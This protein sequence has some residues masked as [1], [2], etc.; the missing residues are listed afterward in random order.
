VA[1]GLSEL[2][3]KIL[4]LAYDRR[5]ENSVLPPDLYGNLYYSEAFHA[6][7]GWPKSI[8]YRSLREAGLI[9]GGP[10]FNRDLVGRARY[11]SARAI[12]SMAVRRLV[13]RGLVKRGLVIKGKYGVILTEEGIKTAKELLANT[14]PST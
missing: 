7:Y 10:N 12:V 13:K 6:L 11:H 9:I 4:I 8:G 1:G 14:I 3:K 2:Q 5:V